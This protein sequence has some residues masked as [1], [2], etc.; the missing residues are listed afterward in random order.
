KLRQKISSS[1]DEMNDTIAQFMNLA[2]GMNKE[3]YSSCSIG[4]VIRNVASNLQ[5]DNRLQL[6]FIR[7]CELQIPQAALQQVLNNIIENALAYG[8]NKPV[9]VE[10]ECQSNGAFIR[11]IDKGPGIPADMIEQ[12]FQPFVRAT[13]NR[14]KGTGLGLAIA[15]LICKTH[16]WTLKLLPGAHGGTT[17]QL[18]LPAQSISETI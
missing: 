10:L 18:H 15:S 9:I 8:D 2:H 6:H 3:N 16:N 13:S 11:V 1:I 17:A 12:I 7:D 14:L 4:N 5:I